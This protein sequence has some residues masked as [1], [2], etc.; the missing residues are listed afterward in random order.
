MKLIC[1][2]SDLA[3]AFQT[4][5]GVVP[6]RTPKAILQNVKIEA[7]S[8]MVTLIG[9]DQ[10]VGIRYRIAEADVQEPGE[11]LLPT[12]RTLAILRELHGETI[13]LESDEETIWLRGERAEYKLSS[14]DPAEFP[15]VSDFQEENYHLISPVILKQMIRRTL[16]AT[17]TE[18]TRYALGGVLIDLQGEGLTLAATDTRR[19]AVVEGKCTVHG[20]PESPATPP[21][22]PS[23]AMSLIERSLGEDQSE[24]VWFAL[25]NNDVMVKT[26]H[27]TLYSRLVEGRFPKYQDV[28]P[29]SHTASIELLA[30]GFYSAVRQAQIVTNEESRGV[31]FEFSAG[32][33]TLR[34]QAAEVGQSKVELPIGYDG[35]DLTITFDP[36][37]VAEFLKVLE[38][39]QQVRLE[40][41]DSES[42]AVFRTGD[43]YVYIIMPLSRDR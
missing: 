8:G 33:L 22:I 39:E 21:V 2:R 31:D 35:P 27:T 4:V 42:A 20:S 37:Y 24:P 14:G 30:S 16:F 32:L 15:V 18:S 43:G 25:R 5:S 6:T 13:S 28:I 41:I 1:Q 11:L 9:T 40:L 19:L 34:S 26:S 23:K 7:Q 29:K 17:D 12:S 36:R 38:P 3:T 10:E